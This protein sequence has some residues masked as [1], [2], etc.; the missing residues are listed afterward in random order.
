MIINKWMGE[1]VDCLPG[2]TQKA[3]PQKDWPYQQDWIV[4]HIKWDAGNR[5]YWIDG[6]HRDNGEKFFWG[7]DYR[8]QMIDG[9]G[10]IVLDWRYDLTNATYSTGRHETVEEARK[11][12]FANK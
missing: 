10:H 4:S 12:E 5:R 1:A 9:V 2:L 3:I 11:R 6:T 8:L 7:M